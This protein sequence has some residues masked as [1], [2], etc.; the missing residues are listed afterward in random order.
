M[1]HCR[2]KPNGALFE[3]GK[4]IGQCEEKTKGPLGSET[5][6]SIQKYQNKPMGVPLGLKTF[7]LSKKKTNKDSLEK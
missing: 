4:N 2:K 7:L 6:F 5:L 1:A 3:N